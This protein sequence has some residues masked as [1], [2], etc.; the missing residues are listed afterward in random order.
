MDERARS[1]VEVEQPTVIRDV[2]VELDAVE[3]PELSRTFSDDVVEW[4][5]P[6]PGE[7]ITSGSLA[8]RD[9]RGPPRAGEDSSPA[10]VVLRSR[11]RSSPDQSRSGGPETT[12]CARTTDSVVVRTFERDPR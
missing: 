12:S 5:A 10:R 8:L 1:P 11:A 7:S 2:A 4:A 6:H 9:E 3:D